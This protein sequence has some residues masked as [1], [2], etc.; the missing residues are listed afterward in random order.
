MQSQVLPSNHVGQQ[1]YR[2]HEQYVPY[3]NTA[4]YA[5]YPPMHHRPS[6][7]S[8]ERQQSAIQPMAAAQDFAP[9]LQFGSQ[10]LR[11]WVDA[12]QR[13]QHQNQSHEKQQHPPS[14]NGVLPN[15]IA[16][17]SSP[18]ITSYSKQTGQRSEM[19]IAMHHP[20]SDNGIIPSGLATASNPTTTRNHMSC[21]FSSDFLFVSCNNS[22]Q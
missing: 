3:T 11:Q 14:G 22:T 21:T 2:R 12:G 19:Q 13:A 18:T 5:L 1:L 9:V 10:H 4:P 17:T 16:T 6:W 20:Q 15:N 8:T 7:S